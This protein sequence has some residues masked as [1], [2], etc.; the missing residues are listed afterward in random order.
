M[1]LLRRTRT[2]PVLAVLLAAVGLVLGMLTGPALASCAQAPGGCCGADACACSLH[3]APESVQA[4]APVALP[5][6]AG[7]VV[8]LA[9]PAADIPPAPPPVRAALPW[10]QPP[11]T[12]PSRAASSPRGPPAGLLA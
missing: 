1:S 12:A 9:T 8:A 4:V 5:R 7:E 10:A 11:P 2:R 6:P 3:C